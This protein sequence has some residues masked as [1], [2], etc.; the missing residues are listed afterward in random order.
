MAYLK[1]LGGEFGGWVLNKTS[2]D[3]K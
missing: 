3:K 1:S 2:F